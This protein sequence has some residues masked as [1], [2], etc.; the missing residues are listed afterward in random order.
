MVIK[1]FNIFLQNTLTVTYLKTRYFLFVFII[2]YFLAVSIDQSI[3]FAQSSPK[4]VLL[5]T[6]LFP[7]PTPSLGLPE[8][9]FVEI[10]NPQSDTISLGGYQLCDADKCYTLPAYKLLPKQCV[11][12]CKATDI[13]SFKSYGLVLGLPSFI[14]LNNDGDQILIKNNLGNIIDQMRYTASM[15]KEGKTLEVQNLTNKCQSITNWQAASASVGGT[16]G[17]ITDAQLSPKL[18]A[19]PAASGVSIFAD[20]IA[21]ISLSDAID[22]KS[23]ALLSAKLDREIIALAASKFD[24]LT[25]TLTITFSRKLYSNFFYQLQINGLQ[26]CYSRAVL[27]DTTL[28]FG[29]P[30]LADSM[31]VV[32]NEILFNPTVGGVDFVE[33]SVASKSKIIDLKNWKIA[34]IQNGVIANQKTISTKSLLIKSRSTI[35]IVSDTNLLLSQYQK[36]GL[37]HQ[38]DLPAFNDDMGVVLLLNADGKIMDR[39]DYNEKMHFEVLKKVEGISLERIYLAAPSQDA[40]NWHSAAEQSGFATPGLPNSQSK[41]EPIE[42]NSWKVVPVAFNPYGGSNQDFTAIHYSIEEFTDAMATLF[43]YDAEGRNIKTIAKNT[44]LS[45]TGFL[46]WDGTDNTG[47]LVPCGQ[48]VLSIQVVNMSGTVKEYTKQVVVTAL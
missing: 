32:I 19:K 18:P 24:S 25:N 44:T 40:A 12:I 8:K 35:A 34:N 22:S 41:D 48:Y 5:I 11:V 31:D 20:S 45:N 1:C 21:T 27:T 4:Q 36:V 28:I 14:S 39:F 47:T 46:R 38:A 15:V 43:I 17:Q 6:E 2:A 10:Y 7:D 16:P 13:E 23:V 9:E 26:D 30:A 3:V 42:D 29:V 37:M 33:L